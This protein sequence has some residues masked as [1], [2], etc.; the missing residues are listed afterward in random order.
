MRRKTEEIRQ[1]INRA[2]HRRNELY[3]AFQH[4]PAAHTG[5]GAIRPSYAANPP[6]Y[7]P[8]NFSGTLH[9]VFQ[10][11]V[12]VLLLCLPLSVHRCMKGQESA[13]TKLLVKVYIPHRQERII[14]RIIPVEIKQDQIRKN[15]CN[16]RR[17]SNRRSRKRDFIF[18]IGDRA[19]MR[20]TAYG[21]VRS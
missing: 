4:Y 6:T 9:Q 7:P 14:Q 15:R 12:S 16:T 11:P 1:L 2:Q 17:K 5:S 21:K 18:H 10:R 3:A 20:L 8:T 13:D 19:A